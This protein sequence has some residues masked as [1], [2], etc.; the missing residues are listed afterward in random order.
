M[1][2]IREVLAQIKAAKTAG[3]GDKL[4][5]VGK[6]EKVLG[7]LSDELQRFYVVL[8]R[9]IKKELS[10][11][12]KDCSAPKPED[13]GSCPIREAMHVSMNRIETIKEMFW[14]AV[15]REIP[16]ALTSPEIGVRKG[17]QV[18]ACPPSDEGEV[19]LMRIPIPAD[20]AA[21]LRL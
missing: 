8:D 10:S 18:V 11:R 20:I 14:G 9:T 3:V 2:F 7:T 5:E 12:M 17:F 21:M 16:G 1:K 19:T 15:R 4:S 13:G 6:G